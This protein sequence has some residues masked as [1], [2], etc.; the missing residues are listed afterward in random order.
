MSISPEASKQSSQALTESLNEVR[1]EP[2]SQDQPTLE[3]NKVDLL[4][5]LSRAWNQPDSAR[6]VVIGT[7]QPVAGH[8]WGFLEDLHHPVTGA[9]LR[10]PIAK[11]RVQDRVFIQS[12]DLRA[13]QKRWPKALFARAEL[14]LSPREERI[15]QEDSFACLVRPGT[16]EALVTIPDEWW[17]LLERGSAPT[18]LMLARARDAI[19]DRLR[20]DTSESE[21]RLQAVHAELERVTLGK[22]TL[23]EDYRRLESAMIEKAEAVAALDEELTNGRI[24]LESRL[25]DLEVLLREKGQRMVALEL[26]DQADFDRAFPSSQTVDDRVGHRFADA[27][28]GSLPRLAAFVQAFLW[29][30]EI[31][32]SRAQLLNFISLLRTNDLIVLAGDSGSG[33][34]SLVKSVAD[35]I[36]GRWTVIPVKPNWTGPDDLLGYYN[37]LERRYQPS[38]F[39]LAL[40]DAAREPDVPHF[41]CLDEMNLARVEYYFADFLSLL[42]TRDEAPWIHLYSTAEERHVTTDNRIFLTLEEEA[43]RRTGLSET[44][45]FADML[46]HDQA[47]LE[48]RRLT[49]FAEADTVIS[50]HAKLRRSISGLIDIPAGFRFPSNVWIIGAVNVDETTHYL[51]PKILDRAH[52]VRFRNPVLVDWDRI[53][54]EVETFTLD[55]DESMLMSASEIGLRE[56]YPPFDPRD[57]LTALLVQW[58]RD[59]LDPLGIEFG[60]RAI[61][62]S[63]NY[64]QKAKQAGIE[65]GAALNQIA[66]Q[67]IL[68]KIMLD[69]EKTAT[70]GASRRDVLVAFRDALS[71]SLETLADAQTT[72]LAVTALDDLIE[73]SATNNGIANF[74]AR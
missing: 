11:S 29:R 72:E 27:L 2:E 63:L 55:M 69:L 1:D 74:W 49:G 24:Q 60:L 65:L 16:L 45:S 54:A 44:A 59:F 8:E 6:V 31:R 32:Y 37:P 36:G 34:T 64:L 28:D 10:A 30:K 38:P 33:K 47:N 39:L 23:D 19:E 71:A 56:P 3:W 73:R 5:F 66:L 68:P 43:R 9:R 21:A 67:K 40:L 14:V 46:I 41:I 15:K 18:P 12:V 25:R 20:I 50:H 48:L 61:R 70:G 7:I 26:V 13:F 62:Q 53:E 35:A 4:A 58:A 42:E 57:A 17:Q 52:V 22:Q 51:S